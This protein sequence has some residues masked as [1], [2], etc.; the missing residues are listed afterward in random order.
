MK[1]ILYRSQGDIDKTV[2]KHELVGVEIG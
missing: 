2:K 1:Y